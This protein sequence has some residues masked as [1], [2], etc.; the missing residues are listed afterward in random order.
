MELP[1]LT[2]AFL[3]CFFSQTGLEN[4]R[5]FDSGPERKILKCN[6]CIVCLGLLQEEFSIDDIVQKVVLYEVI[7]R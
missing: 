4:E 5:E 2:S 3:T 6:P 1:N 7:M